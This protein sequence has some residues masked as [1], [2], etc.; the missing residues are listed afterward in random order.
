MPTP[1]RAQ[2]HPRQLNVQYCVDAR[3]AAQYAACDGVC[4]CARGTA[5]CMQ[6]QQEDRS[7]IRVHQCTLPPLQ[8]QSLTPLLPQHMPHMC[9]PFSHCQGSSTI[10]AHAMTQPALAISAFSTS[11][12]AFL[13]HSSSCSSVFLL[14][15]AFSFAFAAAACRS[16]APSNSETQETQHY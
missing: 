2:L 5:H 6:A 9:A 8:H 7:C 14:L 12:C 15:S 10:N 3:G 16:D 4:A 11:F 1:T 13:N